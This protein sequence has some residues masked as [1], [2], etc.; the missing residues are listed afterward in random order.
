TAAPADDGMAATEEA[1]PADDMAAA[2]TDEETA[3]PADDGMAATEEA[4]P[5]DEETAAAP[6]DDSMTDTDDTETSAI[7]RSSLNEVPV[8]DIRAEDFVGTTVYGSN[9]ENIG[10][11]GDVILT[12][13]GSV[14]AVI[15]DVGGF[16]GIGE[17]E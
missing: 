13:D 1:A 12:D 2:P 10:E 16:L 15:I 14:D 8:G 7:D 5:A 11:I 6:A 4:A 17:K 9:D 3:A